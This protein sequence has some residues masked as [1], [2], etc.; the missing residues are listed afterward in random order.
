MNGMMVLI[1]IVLVMMI[2]TKMV[3]DLRSAA[4]GGGTDCD[5]EDPE[6][7]TLAVE[8]INGLDEKIATVELI[9]TLQDGIRNR[10]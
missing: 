1:V 5:D 8:V 2:M 3:M 4:L 10:L 9:T 6:V 7:N